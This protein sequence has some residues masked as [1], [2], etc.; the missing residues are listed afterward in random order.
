MQN[1]FDKLILLGICLLTLPFTGNQ[2]DAVIILLAAV[3]ISSLCG[4]FENVLPAL[5]SAGYAALCMFFPEFISFLPLIAYDC[6]D[7]G[8]WYFR[9]SWVTALLISFAADPVTAAAAALLSGAAFLLRYRTGR[10]QKTNEDYFA[11]MDSA[12]ERAEDLEQRYSDLME[13]QDY[14]V[15]LATLGERN[16]IARE[17]HD[18]VGH[19]LTRSLLQLGALTVSRADDGGLNEEL[20]DIK[21]T[22]SDAMDSV[23]SSVHGLHDESVD[24]KSRLEAVADGFHFCPVELRYDAGDLPAEIKYCFTAVTREAL[25][26][27]AKHSD[28]TRVFITVTEHPA[29]CQLIISDNGSDRAAKRAYGLGL[30]NMADRVDALGGVFS[31]EQRGGFRI[32]IT[33]PIKGRDREPDAAPVRTQERGGQK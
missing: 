16:R 17:I 29:F 8:A 31:A 10:Q 13:R 18:N 7:L 1:L 21:A 23:R 2:G 24:L 33:A 32:F 30:Q 15:R 26:N 3:S 4:Y 22:L 25:S 6:A 19:L 28:A 20:G 27:T 5:L 11:L 14:E 9:Y 12:K